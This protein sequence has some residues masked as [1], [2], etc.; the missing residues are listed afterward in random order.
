MPDEAGLQATADILALA[1]RAGPDDLALVLVSGGGSAN[2]IAPADRPHHRRQAGADEGAAC[3]R[4]ANLRH[5]HRPKAPLAHQRW[6]PRRPTPS[7]AARYRWRSRT[8]RT[9]ILRSS[10]PARLCPIR[11]PPRMH[12][13]CSA[14]G[15]WTYPRRSEPCLES[16]TGETPKPGDP[17][18]ASA[19]F[20]I[21]ARPADSLE[22]AAAI[23]RA[24]GYDVVVLG[25]ALE[26]EAAEIGAAHGR[27]ALEALRAGRP[28]DL[29][30]GR[31]ADCHGSRR[32]RGRTEPGICAGACLRDRRQR[33]ESPRLPPT[34]TAR[35][36]EAAR[37]AT[38]RARS[39]MPRP[40][41]GPPRWASMPPIS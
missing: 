6:P 36:A 25:D 14:A 11:P 35:T 2:W 26:G 12:W 16:P 27:M 4:R 10:P 41:H 32:R 37:R 33:R 29:P 39:P 22:A 23:G 24:A 19:E 3:L 8:C 20:R 13:L 18:F 28:R 38:R 40:S 30:V 17:V 34:R 31:R 21:I 7:C 15:T 1:D 9:T 5:Q